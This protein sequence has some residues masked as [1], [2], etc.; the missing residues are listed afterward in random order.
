MTFITREKKHV[1]F[2]LI[3]L[4]NIL[5]IKE[6]SCFRPFFLNL[7]FSLFGQF[8]LPWQASCLSSKSW[9]DGSSESLALLSACPF[10]FAVPTTA[11]SRFQW[12]STPQDHW[13]V[14][15]V[16]LVTKLSERWALLL[17]FLSQRKK[18]LT[19]SPVLKHSR[20]V[21]S[22]SCSLPVLIVC[23]CADD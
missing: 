4:F 3:G 16:G 7:C 21:N 2:L 8:K 10:V 19:V 5:F 11:K 17:G 23:A 18:P 13:R 1:I 15:T 12:E 14:S 22:L 6:C 9:C 20:V